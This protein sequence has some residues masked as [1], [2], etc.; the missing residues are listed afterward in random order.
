[1]TIKGF[2]FT[3]LKTLNPRYY[4]SLGETAPSSAVRYFLKI[5]GVLFI[6]MFLIALPKI[7]LIK[8]HL[9]E[10]AIHIS[11]LDV[12]INLETT[13]PILIPQ[14]NPLIVLDTTG[15]RTM[16]NEILLI[17]KDLLFF[18]FAG[19]DQDFP[20]GQNDLV[21]NR[22]QMVSMFTGL[23][24]LILPTLFLIYYILYVIK[25]FLIIIPV[26]FVTYAFAK[27]MGN[28][29]DFKHMLSL[30]FYTSTIMI[31]IEVLTIP[32][33]WNKYLLMHS[34]IIGLNFSIIAI[35]AYLTL[36]ITA[37]RVMGNRDLS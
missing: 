6:L 32:F 30:S 11:Q 36:F 18:Q 10:A 13:E 23:F 9:N 20:F 27:P 15:N 22:R 37:V 33:N 14:K 21:E 2:I 4:R 25:Y 34:P 17:T 29:L 31:I 16:Q 1:M 19:N 12:N 7:L 3:F 24:L 26:A 8:S 35:T 28:A 5:L